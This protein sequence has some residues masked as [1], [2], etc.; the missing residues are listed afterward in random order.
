MNA[1]TSRKVLA[2]ID[3]VDFN[4]M[5]ATGYTWTLYADGRVS[6]EWH[7]R[8]QGS[9]DGTR[10]TTNEGYVD[11]DRIN[12]DDPDYT[13]ESF[14]TVATMGIHLDFDDDFRLTRRGA[15]VQ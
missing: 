12:E 11:V 8:W 13:A 15:I 9:R 14:L 2:T 3:D 4:D 7:S 1:V 5:A 6:A 10:Y